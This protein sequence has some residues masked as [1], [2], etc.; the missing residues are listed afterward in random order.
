MARIAKRRPW[1]TNEIRARRRFGEETYLLGP[2]S[3]APPSE[4]PGPNLPLPLTGMI[5]R[6]QCGTHPSADHASP[7]RPGSCQLHSGTP[8]GWRCS[9][10]GPT[11]RIG[12]WSCQSPHRPWSLPASLVQPGPSSTLRCQEIAKRLLSKGSVSS[13]TVAS[14]WVKRIRISRRVGLAK[15]ANTSL[16]VADGMYLSRT[17]CQLTYWPDISSRQVP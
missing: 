10:Y 9:P 7:E 15:S 4:T 2:I 3:L 13:V 5:P 6:A 12:T 1:P 8:S 16:M 11:A 14:P 17:I